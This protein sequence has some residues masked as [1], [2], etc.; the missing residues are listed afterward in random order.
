M[1]K[2]QCDDRLSSS[3][4][5]IG[6]AVCHFGTAAARCIPHCG[7]SRS[8]LQQG[9]AVLGRCECLASVPFCKGAAAL[10]PKE[11]QALHRV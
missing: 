3:F 5:H 1:W 4:H 2:L 7:Y 6:S 10:Q 11:L 8:M 9:S